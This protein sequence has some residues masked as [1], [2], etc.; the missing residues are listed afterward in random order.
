M[1]TKDYKP[2]QWHAEAFAGLLGRADRLPHALLLLGPPGV[3]KSGF[4]MA[5]AAAL[6]CENRSGAASACGQCAACGWLSAGSHPDFRL[7]SRLV[8]DDGKQ[9]GD[10]RVDQIRALSEF[11]VVG[12]HRG[13]RRVVVIDPADAMNAVVAN[14]LLKTLEEPGAGLIFILVSAR[15]DAI[16]ATIRSRCQVVALPAPGLEEAGAWVQGATGCSPAD[17]RAWLAMAGG[18]PLTAAGLAEPT[19]AAAHRSM[20]EA[21]A[22]MPDTPP[23][24]VADA[25]QGF[26]ARLWLPLLQRWVMDIARTG[27]GAPPRY[28]PQWAQRLQELSARSNALGLAQAGRGLAGQFRHVG[29]P[30]NPRLFCEESLAWV[31]SA[32][33]PAIAEDRR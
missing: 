16:P 4:A 25:L 33:R 6:L 30:L 31:A 17:A 28:F 2:M 32:F 24:D 13:G 29:H 3:G 26:E 8:D 19:V 9:A 12:A 23:V 15:S 22:R 5:L 7:L 11:L 10:I 1:N 18:S 21:I 27:Q 14:A 20:L